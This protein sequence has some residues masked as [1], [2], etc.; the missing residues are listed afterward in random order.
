MI[1]ALLIYSVIATIAVIVIS[2][3]Y[4]HDTKKLQE[5]ANH[6]EDRVGFH[7]SKLL[8]INNMI[9]ETEKTNGNLL[10]LVKDIKKELDRLPTKI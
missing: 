2:I 3:L 10:Y 7:F 5:I 1:T 6:S 9:R 4:I 8:N